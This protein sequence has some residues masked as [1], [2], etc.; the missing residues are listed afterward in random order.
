MKLNY[1][2]LTIVIIISAC[3]QPEEVLPDPPQTVQMVLR[4]LGADTLNVERGIDAAEN[5]ESD[6]LNGIQLNWYKHP[7]HSD[8][9]EY[10]IYRSSHSSGL[11]NFY[12]HNSKEVNQPGII[13]TMFID[14]QDLSQNVRYYYYVTAMDKDDQDSQASDTV[15]YTLIEKAY[16]LSILGYSQVINQPNI[17]FQWY[18][19]QSAAEYI[20]RI[21]E[22]QGD[23]H[24]LV[25]SKLIT[26]IY[27]IPEVHNLSG[28]WMKTTF[29]DRDY[30]WRIDCVVAEDMG[31]IQAQFFSGSESEWAYFTV[32]W[33]N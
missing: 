6:A 13:D 11:V 3:S 9:K 26:S 14:T 32:K 8:L 16:D 24:K 27:D 17:D 30:R 20:L 10:R 2:S 33:S 29:P 23:Y 15:S 22:Y 5:P 12:Y 19:S 25:Y 28:D 7:D 21:E 4:T 31:N 18:R 1:L